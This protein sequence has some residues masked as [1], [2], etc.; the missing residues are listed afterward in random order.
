[1]KAAVIAFS[2]YSRIPMPAF[3]W[4]EKDKRYAMCFFP[5]V[6]VVLGGVFYLVFGLLKLLGAGPV[7]S[8]AILAAVPF[9]VTGGIHLDGFLDTCDARASYGDREKKLAI[10]KDSH[11]GAFAVVSGVLYLLLYAAACSELTGE[12]AVLLALGFPISRAGSGLFTVLLP[13]ARKQ[14]MLADFMRDAARRAVVWAM[15]GY[16]AVF[17]LGLLLLGGSIGLLMVLAALGCFF[18]CRRVFLKEFGGITGDL[19]GYFLQLCELSL[20]L[21]AVFGGLFR[22]LFG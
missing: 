3:P 20:L 9:F 8:G 18:Y 7:L 19:A 4:E 13:E 15:G 11:T 5:A 12:T 1:M 17:G 16:L 10:L 14:G 21:S 22:G 2:M 6:G